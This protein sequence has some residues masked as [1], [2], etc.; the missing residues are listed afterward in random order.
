[1]Y[2]FN[3]IASRVP[4]IYVLSKNKK[5]IKN[6]STEKCHFYSYKNRC[7]LYRHVYVMLK[8]RTV[9]MYTYKQWRIQRGSH[10]T[11]FQTT[12]F[13]FRREIS[14]KKRTTIYKFE[15]SFQKSWTPHGLERNQSPALEKYRTVS[16]Y[17]I[18]I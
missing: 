13:H 10:D 17:G 14:E 4:T 7:I 3:R 15:P 18:S 2:T 6:F 8:Y 12:L 9:W 1:M 5:N 11:P 16:I